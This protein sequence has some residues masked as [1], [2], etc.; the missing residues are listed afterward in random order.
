VSLVAYAD[1]SVPFHTLPLPYLFAAVLLHEDEETARQ[2]REA[3]LPLQHAPKGFHWTHANDDQRGDAIDV[4][5]SFPALHLTVAGVP[6]RRDKQERARRICLEAF[7]RELESAGVEHVNF[8]SRGSA[9]NRRDLEVVGGFRAQR[10]LKSIRVQHLDPRTEPL[11]W[12]ADA[13]AGALGCHL[14][15]ESHH[16][17]RIKDPVE[18]CDIHLR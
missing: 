7:L 10:Y 11:L 17:E 3:M 2:L 5:C 18:L 6:V 4:I 1:E 13:V 15:G 16:W 14:R 8:E 12:V 9:D